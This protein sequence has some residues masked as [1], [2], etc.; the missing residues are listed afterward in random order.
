MHTMVKYEASEMKQ[1]PAKMKLQYYLLTCIAI[2]VLFIIEDARP[3]H[4]MLDS[5]LIYGALGQILLLALILIVSIYFGIINAYR[6]WTYPFC[7][8]F[9]A[10]LAVPYVSIIFINQPEVTRYF[11]TFFWF[12]GFIFIFLPLV[13][14]ACLGIGLGMLM[15]KRLNHILKIMP[16][17]NER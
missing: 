2:I 15:R 8:G 12:I 6:K 3:T 5:P 9:F 4:H 10:Y 7:V 1:L 14:I 17:K 13:V 11:V 16:T